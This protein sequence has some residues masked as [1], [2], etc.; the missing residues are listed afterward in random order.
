MQKL[1][2]PRARAKV[3]RQKHDQSKN[4]SKYCECCFFVK[5]DSVPQLDV[6]H[7]DAQVE[8][9]IQ[10]RLLELNELATPGM[11]LK[12]KSQRGGGDKF[13]SR[14]VRWP[15]EFVLSGTEKESFFL[16]PV[17]NFPVGCWLL[18]LHERGR[19][20]LKMRDPMLDYLISLLDDSQDLSWLAAK[21]SHSVLL[22]HMEQG[23]IE[24]YSKI[25]QIDIIRR[26]HAQRHIQNSAQKCVKSDIN[27]AQK[28]RKSM[29]CIYFNQNTYSFNKTH[30]TG[31]W[32]NIP[33]L[34]QCTTVRDILVFSILS[35]GYQYIVNTIGGKSHSPSFD[36]A[37]SKGQHVF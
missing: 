35:I 27:F 31:Q 23:E 28:Q 34:I 22:C 36:I 32:S 20:K 13:V 3:E 33:H 30:E 18:P 10:Q 8:Q 24:D 15:Q 19:K 12:I 5:N 17:D 7:Q 2:L 26:A 16:R 25:E 11:P 9:Q 14:C 37:K 4:I 6:L 21:A 29:P 1:N